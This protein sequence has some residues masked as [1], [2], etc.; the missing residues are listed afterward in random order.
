MKK[1]LFILILMLSSCDKLGN[2]D[3][4]KGVN[5]CFECIK[6]GYNCEY[7]YDIALKLW[8]C[9]RTKGGKGRDAYIY[10]WRKN[11]IK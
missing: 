7:R 9:S 5:E 3:L 2:D 8:T 6:N 4:V 10:G 11:R 1:I